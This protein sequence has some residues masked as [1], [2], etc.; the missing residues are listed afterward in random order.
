MLLMPMI[1]NRQ[2][3]RLKSNR[4]IRVYSSEATKQSAPQ[5]L[6]KFSERRA[7]SKDR[8]KN[9]VPVSLDRRRGDRRNAHQ[10][11]R[12]ELKTLLQNAGSNNPATVRR[13]GVYINEDV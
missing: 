11:L 2:I 9:S 7:R 8:R 6:P 12:P 1:H 10:A 3:E 5:Q 4:S 13:E